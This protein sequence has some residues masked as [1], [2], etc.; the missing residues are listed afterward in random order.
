MKR[1]GPSWRWA[2][3][4]L[5]G[6]ALVWFG[7]LLW[8]AVGLPRE[9]GDRETPSDGIVVLTGGSERLAA[10]LDLLA[11][12][13]AKKLFVSGVD[14]GTNLAA[15]RDANPSH[16]AVFDCCV[17][18]GREALDTAGNARE[19]SRWAAAQGYR[20]LRIV[21]AGYHMPRALLELR[22]AMPDVELLANPVFPEHVKIER[23]WAWPGTAF[24]IAREFT[25][26]A[27]SLARGS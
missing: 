2:A 9:V 24:L 21:T 12:G 4:V 8:Y 3:R 16:A 27:V 23:W 19:V 17:E 15:L 20:S 26:Y 5:F 22:R 14:T 13:K 18:I 10:G 11:A 6:V 7:G 1:P 25:K